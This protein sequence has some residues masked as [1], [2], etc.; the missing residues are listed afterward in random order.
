MDRSFGAQG[1]GLGLRP[2]PQSPTIT[3]NS[4]A[5]NPPALNGGYNRDPNIKAPKKS[6]S[7]KHGSTIGI[8]GP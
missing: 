3:P 4:V 1:L 8:V 5:L 7:M 2:K 6:G